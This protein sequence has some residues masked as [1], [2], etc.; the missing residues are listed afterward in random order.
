MPGYQLVERVREYGRVLLDFDEDGFLKDPG[1]WSQELAEII[2]ELDGIGSLGPD[3]W[4]IISYLREHHLKYG[5]LPVMSHVCRKQNLKKR[6][7]MDLFGGCREAWRVSGL[8]NPGEEAKS[9]M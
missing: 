6:A 2:A 4:S 8:P 7:V 5:S 3:H 9:Y 1:V